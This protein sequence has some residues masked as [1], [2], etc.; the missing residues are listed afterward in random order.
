MPIVEKAKVGGVRADGS[1]ILLPETE[2]RITH[3]RTGKEYE[4]EEDAV[5]DVSN[6]DTDTCEE[7]IC[8]STTLRVLQGVDSEGSTL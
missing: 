7:D 1:K 5:A 2:V 8:R 3:A 6:P 4:C